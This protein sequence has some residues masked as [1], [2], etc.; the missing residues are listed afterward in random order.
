MAKWSKYN[1]LVEDDD[2][3]LF[4][5]TRTGSLIRLDSDRQKQITGSSEIPN[6]FLSLLLNHGFLVGDDVDELELIAAIHESAR[7]YKDSFSAT[8]EL[9]QACN[10]R[11]LYCYQTHTL[12]HMQNQVQEH[13]ISYLINKIRSV[14][15]LHINWFGGEPLIRLNSL[16]EMSQ[17]LKAEADICGCTYSQFLTTNGY[18][19]TQ[20]VAKELATIGIENVQITLDGNEEIHN[21][22]RVHASGEGTYKRV[23]SACKFVV[24]NDMELL[25]RINLNRL[26][27]RQIDSLLSD[28]VSNGITP[29]NTIIHVT[30]AVNHGNLND[31]MSSAIFSP[32]EFAK[33]WIGILQTISMYGFNLPTLAPLAYNCPFDL[34]RTVMIGS[35]GGIRHCSSSDHLIAD[36]TETGNEA[37]R[38]NLYQIIKERRP[39]EDLTCKECLYLPMCMGGC[40]Y[41]QEIGEEKCIPERYI[42]PELILLSADQIRQKS[43]KIEGG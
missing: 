24:D 39:W 16:K 21:R 43:I 22:L 29:T 18:M 33:A 19:I 31:K 42:L 7:D 25:V 32:E 28:L 13:V 35:D 2:Y 6:D 23:L 27:F 40:S 11:C 3:I 15:H 36:I 37:D 38:T 10:F 17:R 5:N 9:T 8:I 34:K 26:N 30:R 12:N 14:K 20:S 4:F 1:I 41:L